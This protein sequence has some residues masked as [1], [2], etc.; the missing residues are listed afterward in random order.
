MPASCWVFLT[1]ATAATRRN[2]DLRNLDISPYVQDD[3][4]LSPRLTLNLGIRWDIQ[5]PFTENH[6]LIV[7]FDPDNPGPIRRPAVFPEA[8]TNSAIAPVAPD[9]IAPISTGDTS[10]RASDLHIS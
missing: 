8:A 3:I 1:Q 4:K 2:C 10:G 7:F 5:V 9:I 6:N